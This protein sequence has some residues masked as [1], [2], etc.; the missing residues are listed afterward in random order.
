ME[1]GDLCKF[2]RTC[3][4]LVSMKLKTLFG[5][6]KG[7]KVI[8]SPADSTTNLPIQNMSHINHDFS[9]LRAVISSSS[10]IFLLRFSGELG[11]S[12]MRELSVTTRID[13]RYPM[14]MHPPI[15][16]TRIVRRESIPKNGAVPVS[17]V[18]PS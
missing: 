5:L 8:L 16:V 10:R 13:E 7:K 18:I 9:D 4:R 14:S 15:M 17:L 12:M 3:L 11:C 2:F 6:S 1:A